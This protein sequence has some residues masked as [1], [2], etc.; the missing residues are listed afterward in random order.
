MSEAIWQ[1]ESFVDEAGHMIQ[2]FTHQD[3]GEVHYAADGVVTKRAGNQLHQLPFHFNIPANTI[4]EAFDRF[5]EAAKVALVE[6]EKRLNQAIAPNLQRA[7][8]SILDNRGRL[9]LPGGDPGGNGKRK[10]P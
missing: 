7:P 4:A 1:V 6:V 9:I 8:A 2:R 5:E 3:T 10:R